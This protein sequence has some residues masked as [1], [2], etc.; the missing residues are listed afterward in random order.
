[1][2]L[3]SASSG[4]NDRVWLAVWEL[5]AQLSGD[6]NL[7]IHCWWRPHLFLVRFLLC[8]GAAADRQVLLDE[9]D[10]VFLLFYLSRTLHVPSLSGVVEY[11]GLQLQ[12]RSG[13][14]TGAER[15]QEGTRR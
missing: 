9:L 4:W 11:F 12:Q 15:V 14:A 2:S 3:H 10:C 1:M 13:A 6:I 8:V 7:F 5:A